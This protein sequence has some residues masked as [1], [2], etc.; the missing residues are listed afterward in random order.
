[1][2]EHD[3][4]I[5]PPEMEEARARRAELRARIKHDLISQ[6][7]TSARLAGLELETDWEEGEITGWRWSVL[8]RD[9]PPLRYTRAN[10]EGAPIWRDGVELAPPTFE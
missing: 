1:M 5:I 8:L 2:T 6:G 10:Q 9:G 3:P 4:N 7:I